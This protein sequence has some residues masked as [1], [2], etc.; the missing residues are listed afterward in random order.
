MLLYLEPNNLFALIVRLQGSAT[1]MDFR[2]FMI[3]GRVRADDS[4]AGTFSN[5][6]NYQYACDGN[7]SFCLRSIYIILP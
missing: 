1:D 6:T 2:G 7:V 5:G 3:Q 4:P